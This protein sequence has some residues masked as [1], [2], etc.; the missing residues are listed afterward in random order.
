MIIVIVCF[1][2]KNVDRAPPHY[3]IS[4][5]NTPADAASYE[6]DVARHLNID[7]VWADCCNSHTN[8]NRGV[9]KNNY[10]KR[11]KLEARIPT[12]ID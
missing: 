9:S 7:F 8:N 12:S 2:W 11:P 3:D 5:R 1:Q 6:T 4:L 10:Q